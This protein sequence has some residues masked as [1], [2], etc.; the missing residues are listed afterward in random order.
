MQLFIWLAN[1]AYDNIELTFPTGHR[2]IPAI[3]NIPSKNSKPSK[4]FLQIKEG[5]VSPIFRDLQPYIERIAVI[6]QVEFDIDILNNSDIDSFHLAIILRKA[7]PV[8]AMKNIVRMS[9]LFPTRGTFEP[10]LV[11]EGKLA[12]SLVAAR[13]VSCLKG[14]KS[15]SLFFCLLENSDAVSCY[16]PGNF[17][18]TLHA[19]LARINAMISNK[20]I[21]RVKNLDFCRFFWAAARTKMLAAVTAESELEIPLTG[22]QIADQL[23]KKYPGKSHWINCLYQEYSRE[24]LGKENELH[25]FFA[26]AVD[27]LYRM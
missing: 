20:E 7:L 21:F 14:I 12:F 17:E 19:R 6:P 27:F 9:R 25:L 23:T 26:D 4:E 22:R 5:E 11:W 24:L 2:Q 1:R 8:S 16:L 3:V 10:F 18:K 15:D 13:P